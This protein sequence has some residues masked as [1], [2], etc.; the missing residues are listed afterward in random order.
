VSQKIL[1]YE[2][3]RCTFS[4]GKGRTSEECKKIGSSGKE[5]RIA[6]AQYHNIVAAAFKLARESSRSINFYTF[7]FANN[8]TE[9][10]ANCAIGKFFKE[11][12]RGFDNEL[13]IRYIWTKERQ[14]NGKIH[15][16][17]LLDSGFIPV[18]NLQNLWNRCIRFACGNVELSNNSFRLPPP[19]NRKIF[20]NKDIIAIAK[21]IGKYVSKERF[22]S[23][24]LPVYSISKRL[25]PLSREISIEEYETLVDTF[26]IFRSSV[27]EFCSVIQLNNAENYR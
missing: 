19:A 6:N 18:K 2:N 23:Y 10:E 3:G 4:A 26:G 14:K 5:Y 27:Y 9:K 7:T 12:L 15:F 1:L 22:N 20:A 11:L 17:S 21:Y 8:P 25:F 13:L 24:E 16:H